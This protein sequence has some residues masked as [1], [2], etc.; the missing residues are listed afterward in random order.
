EVLDLEHAPGLA[1]IDLVAGRARTR[2]RRDFGNRE[3]TLGKN[4]EHLATDVSGRADNHH[5]I[6]HGSAP[7]MRTAGTHI[8]RRPSENN[9]RAGS[10]L[11]GLFDMAA[12]APLGDARRL[13]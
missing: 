11:G 9:S 7:K 10:A 8:G 12:F 6:R 3:F 4:V 5:T 1:E 13:T 2:H